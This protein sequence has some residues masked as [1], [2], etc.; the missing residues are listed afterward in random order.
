VYDVIVIGGGHNGLTC[1]AYLAKAGRRVAVIES[2]PV[3][4]GF[5]TTVENVAAA[6]GFKMNPCALDTALTNTPVSIIDELRLVEDHGLRFVTPDPWAGWANPEGASIAMWRD[7][8]RTVA[9]IARFSRHDAT[10]FKDFIETMTGVWWAMMPYFQGHPTRPSAKV[11]GE[12]AWRA[13]KS[14]KGLRKA[15]RVFAGS[16]HQ[17]IEETFEREEVKAM[18]G[19]LAAWSMLPLHEPGSGGVLAMMCAYFRWGVTRPVGGSG[20]FPAALGRCIEAHGGEVRTDAPVDEVLVSAG[21]IATGVRL[22]DGTELQARQVIGALDPHTLMRGLVPQDHVPQ[23]TQLELNAFGALRW[24][25]SIFKADV[26]LDRRPVL[27]CG[28]EELLQGYLLIAP[29]LEYILEAQRKMMYGEI[30]A[31]IV[32]APA[33]PSVIDRTQ[34]PGGSGGDTVYLYGP[35]APLHL[36]DDRDWDDHIDAFVDDALAMMDIYAPGLKDSVI[37]TFNKSPKDFAKQ[38]YRGNIVHT[39]MSMSMMGP[40]R[41]IPSMSGYRTPV[42]NLWHTAAGAHPMGALNGWSG[43]TT[44]R[45]VHKTMDKAPTAPASFTPAASNGATPGVKVPVA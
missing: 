4:G 34:V 27:A 45:T 32:M 39:D 24:N 19:S 10:A 43:R 9:E 38:S 20:E 44:A 15:A 31:E 30:P 21:G 17:I 6:P 29:T 26:A 25:L 23:E 2:Q 11:I 5:C 12:V 18:V 35:G 40:W 7:L 36:T 37:G 42:T 22:Q 8:D 16:P 41:P 3:L 14:H 28:R 13:M 1:A 33:F